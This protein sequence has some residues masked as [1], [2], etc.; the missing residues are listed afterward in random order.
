MPLSQSW[1]YYFRLFDESFDAWKLPPR[2]VAGKKD[3]EESNIL[4]QHH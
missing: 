1:T 3:L 2:D 4:C